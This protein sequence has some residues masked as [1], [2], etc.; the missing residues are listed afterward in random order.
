MFILCENEKKNEKNFDIIRLA[1]SSESIVD[2]EVG[3]SRNNQFFSILFFLQFYTYEQKVNYDYSS[4]Y[5]S[6]MTFNF[7]QPRRDPVKPGLYRWLTQL[8]PAERA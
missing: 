3:R 5:S 4:I 8:Q 7:S 6:M 2:Y 1:P